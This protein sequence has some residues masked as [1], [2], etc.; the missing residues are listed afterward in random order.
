A[1]SSGGNVPSAITSGG[2]VAR[3][4]GGASRR[5][6]SRRSRRGR[7]RRGDHA[8]RRSRLRLAEVSSLTVDQI[9]LLA[10]VTALYLVT[11]WLRSIAATQRWSVRRVTRTV[12]AAAFLVL[13]GAR[14]GEPSRNHSVSRSLRFTRSAGPRRRGRARPRRARPGTAG[15]SRRGR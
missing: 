2:R 10:G 5:S 12:Q 15:G 11:Y 7:V 6:C 9:A 14:H 1:P 4:V 13:A 8:D 3:G